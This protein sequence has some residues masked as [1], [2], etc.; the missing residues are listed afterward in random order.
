MLSDQLLA[1]LSPVPRL[2]FFDE[3]SDNMIEKNWEVEYR[4]DNEA[5]NEGP[6]ELHAPFHIVNPLC[7]AE[8]MVRCHKHSTLIEYFLHVLDHSL[9]G[10]HVG[11]VAHDIQ[12]RPELRVDLNI[13]FLRQ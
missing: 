2:N 7:E 4:V 13:S 10:Q 11:C 9:V 5:S 3:A 1:L 6:T 12:C 8:E